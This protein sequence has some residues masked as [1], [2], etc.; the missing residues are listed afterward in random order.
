LAQDDRLR[1][2]HHIKTGGRARKADARF[3]VPLCAVCHDDLHQHGRQSFEDRWAIWLDVEADS[4]EKAWQKFQ[5]S[6]TGGER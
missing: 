3:I 4:T 1:E 6:D 5:R 2:N